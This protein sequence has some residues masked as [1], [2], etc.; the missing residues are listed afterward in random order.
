[1]ATLLNSGYERM[2]TGDGRETARQDPRTL[3]RRQDDA[4]GGSQTG[5][6]HRQRQP[7]KPWQ[8]ELYQSNKALTVIGED[9]ADTTGQSGGI[10]N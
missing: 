9:C 5:N 2:A 4:R 6:F 7:V 8:A 3:P 1:V 10:Y